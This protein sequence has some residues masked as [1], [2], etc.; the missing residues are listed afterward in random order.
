MNST[1]IKILFVEDHPL[2][3]EGY[4]RALKVLKKQ[5]PEWD[6][7][8]AEA[9][10]SDAAIYL[11]DH[12]LPPGYDLVM[13]D[14]IIPPSSCGRWLSGEDIGREVRQR[15][16]HSKLLINTSFDSVFRMNSLF[17]S[18]NPE[19]FLIKAESNA[20]IIMEA[21]RTLLEGQTYYSA[22]VRQLLRKNLSNT[23]IIDQWDRQIL[24]HLSL[25]ATTV[26]LSNLLPMSKATV[27]RRKRHLKELFDV[28]G[29]DDQ[30][31]LE[32]ARKHGFI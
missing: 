8:I 6:F 31:L 20:K 15:H 26:S 5:R 4:A 13:L 10:S 16:P 12:V 27:E 9:A 30:R 14:L 17:K 2:I 19:G 32:R 7:K 3:S 25:G 1:P 23:F 22:S 29:Q 18:V 24:H 21:I 28:E 11:L